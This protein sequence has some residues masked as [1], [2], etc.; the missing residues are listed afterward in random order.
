MRGRVFTAAEWRCR[1]H[2]TIYL[3]EFIRQRP[4]PAGCGGV[5]DAWWRTNERR[6]CHTRLTRRARGRRLTSFSP[7]ETTDIP[8]F[9]H[10]VLLSNFNVSDFDVFQWERMLLSTSFF[11]LFTKT[12]PID[13]SRR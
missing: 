11:L 8:S 9:Y 6:V 12:L 10:V 3:G 5:V 4:T 2:F 13:A 7:E 1:F